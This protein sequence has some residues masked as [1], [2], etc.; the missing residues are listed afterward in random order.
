[1]P[2]QKKSSD[3][4]PA[5]GPENPAKREQNTRTT[6]AGRVHTYTQTE[7]RQQARLEMAGL[8]GGDA[9]DD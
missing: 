2:A 7:R 5:I 6:E 8:S 3:N 9:V 4:D 1:M